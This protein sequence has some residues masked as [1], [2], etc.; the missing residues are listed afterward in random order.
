ML[1]PLLISLSILLSPL[2][3]FSADEVGSF[4]RAKKTTVDNKKARV[5]DIFKINQLIK[6]GRSS[7][8]KAEITTK[9]NSRYI[10]Y[11][12][13]SIKFE[14]FNMNGSACDG[15]KVSLSQGKMRGTSGACGDGKTEI[16][17]AVA[18]AFAWGTDYEM[19]FVPEGKKIE[20]YENVKAG[21][22]Q[23]VNEG[24]VM[25]ENPMGS[26]LVNPGEAGFVSTTGAAPVIVPLPDFFTNT[27]KPTPKK[28]KKV[29]DKESKKDK[30]K[31]KNSKNKKKP[32]SKTT[33]SK[34]KDKKKA[35]ESKKKSKKADKDESNKNP[36]DEKESK[37]TEK[38][39]KPSKERKPSES[40]SKSSKESDES[41]EKPNEEAVDKNESGSD[42]ESAKK[43]TALRDQSVTPAQED[44]G[45]DSSQESNK[46]ATTPIKKV[47]QTAS[48]NN[49]NRGKAPNV[50]APKVAPDPPV[51]LPPMVE[52]RP[53][54]PNLNPITNPR[55]G[56][57]DVGDGTE[58][59]SNKPK[60]KA[61][62]KIIQSYERDNPLDGTD[63]KSIIERLNVDLYD[64][65][66]VKRTLLQTTTTTTETIIDDDWSYDDTKDIR[67]NEITDRNQQGAL[68]SDT[69]TE[70]NGKKI[71]KRF[72]HKTTYDLNKYKYKSIKTRTIVTVTNPE[73][74]LIAERS[75]NVTTEPELY[76]DGFDFERG[77]TDLEYAFDT[78]T[79]KS[80]HYTNWVDGETRTEEDDRALSDEPES[81]DYRYKKSAI[82]PTPGSR[83]TEIEFSN[84]I[85]KREI[86]TQ[87]RQFGEKTTYQRRAAGQSEITKQGPPSFRYVKTIYEDLN[88]RLITVKGDLAFTRKIEHIGYEF[89]NPTLSDN[90]AKIDDNS[91][92]TTT[93]STKDDILFPHENTNITITNKSEITTNQYAAKMMGKK[94]YKT[95]DYDKAEKELTSGQHQHQNTYDDEAEIEFDADE[96]EFLKGYI[97]NCDKGAGCGEDAV[98]A[99]N[100]LFNDDG[101]L[102]ISEIDSEVFLHTEIAGSEADL[103][104][105]DFNPFDPT[106]DSNPTESAY[107]ITG[108]HAD[109]FVQKGTGNSDNLKPKLEI[110]SDS[111]YDDAFDPIFNQDNPLEIE[112]DVSKGTGDNLTT[113]K[114]IFKPTDTRSGTEY[115]I[116]S[117]HA[118]IT[119]PHQIFDQHQSYQDVMINNNTSIITIGLRSSSSD[120]LSAF[121]YENNQND[122]NNDDLSMK[123]PKTGKLNY[124]IQNKSPVLV[125]GEKQLDSNFNS[126]YELISADTTVNFSNNKL[127]TKITLKNNADSTKNITSQDIETVLGSNGTFDNNEALDG[128]SSVGTTNIKGSMM[129][130]NGSH[131]GMGY[132][133]VEKI[134]QSQGSLPNV[135]HGTVLLKAVSREDTIASDRQENGNLIL[136]RSNQDEKFDLTEM[137]SSTPYNTN[138]YKTGFSADPFKTTK[139]G[140]DE[141][142]HK[143]VSDTL[144]ENGDTKT[145]FY[146]AS[147]ENCFSW[148]GS[149]SVEDRKT[150][151]IIRSDYVGNFGEKIT[152][153]S[154]TKSESTIHWGWWQNPHEAKYHRDGAGT[155][156]IVKKSGTNPLD[157]NSISSLF[158]YEDFAEMADMDGEMHL[159]ISGTIDY[160]IMKNSDLIIN[161][162]GGDAVSD[163]YYLS[164]A[165]LEINF[166]DNGLN[167]E[168][169]IGSKTNGD[170]FLTANGSGILDQA[171]GRFSATG[172]LEGTG[173]FGFADNTSTLPK[174]EDTASHGSGQL[175]GTSNQ[176]L[177]QQINAGEFAAVGAMMGVNGSH[178]GMGFKMAIKDIPQVDENGQ[179][180]DNTVSGMVL[181]KQK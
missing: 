93:S 49:P 20:G 99:F 67:E 151:K 5:G 18:A 82:N 103:K 121:I 10:L 164:S 168:I 35:K 118:D 100:A 2:P 141:R 153:N 176:Y 24:K 177:N 145:L 116:W 146:C 131:I 73:G 157:V 33:K 27:K 126:V 102:V 46:Q 79:T 52:K 22:Y 72:Y 154:D 124:E 25:V 71:T 171:T 19:V 105:F 148:N 120:P 161:A 137:V 13:S 6:T 149:A 139:A 28:K 106:D 53:Q 96:K 135:A 37:N 108:K 166:S 107:N 39:D 175:L 128:S 97:A 167:T 112:I 90:L 98:I 1:K 87:T 77:L 43:K 117:G 48:S 3:A 7:R 23:K 95:T 62:P 91:L 113:T 68:D 83:I 26:L 140:I 170:D 109:L 64:D 81:P 51:S 58:Q 59:K 180:F 152:I 94:V 129:G 127:K 14:E 41:S 163:E 130:T 89:D 60:A 30:S 119:S 138:Q 34:D 42:G 80:D 17:T 9:D 84:A 181:F 169:G 114:L 47:E 78:I 29:K 38:K 56:V 136:L 86:P 54:T 162:S 16:K 76:V 4:W 178:A 15:M 125:N 69:I 63:N 40:D 57:G 104:D 32:A 158:L 50:S 66:T 45:E 111:L 36:D 142:N 165:S 115:R 75:S 122:F 55:L 92:L 11:K 150:K 21:F 132:R 85:A 65:G 70:D 74:G 31:A 144:D 133:M 44:A 172:G 101:Q 155:R 134:S 61:Q 160:E 110:I 123:L 143:Y 179:T 174:P 159:P 12:N 147:G 156:E 8:S 88:P 173:S